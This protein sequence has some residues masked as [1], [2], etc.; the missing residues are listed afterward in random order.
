VLTSGCAS[1]ATLTGSDWETALESGERAPYS[2]VLIP[3]DSYRYYQEDS[4]LYPA[5]VER[6]KEAKCAQPNEPWFSPRQLSFL[7]S[8]VVLGLITA[9]KT[10]R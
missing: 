3:E 10:G 9:S 5:C 7:L 8:G 6:L 1:G 4:A 2:G